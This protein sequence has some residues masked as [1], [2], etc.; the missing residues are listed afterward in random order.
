MAC[1]AERHEHQADQQQDQTDREQHRE[2]GYD[3][4]HDDQNDA[5]NDHALTL[6]P[7]MK[8]ET[9]IVDLFLG[10]LFWLVLVFGTGWLGEQ[11]LHK[12]RSR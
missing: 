5:E 3:Q 6:P 12:I 10:I 8:L 2:L 11:I 1:V 7:T 4:A 9:Q